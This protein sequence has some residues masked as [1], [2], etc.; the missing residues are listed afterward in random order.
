MVRVFSP[1]GYTF[2]FSGFRVSGLSWARS[3]ARQEESLPRWHR[4]RP[5][6]NL[7]VRAA[8]LA[9]SPLPSRG[10]SHLSQPRRQTRPIRLLGRSFSDRRNWICSLFK[11]LNIKNT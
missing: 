7:C 4:F 1:T 6:R 3:P 10:I 8:S 2:L 11:R 5:P 9:A